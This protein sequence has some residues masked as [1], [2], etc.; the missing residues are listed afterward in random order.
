[1]IFAA[2]DVSKN[3]IGLAIS[4]NQDVFFSTTIFL[5]KPFKSHMD[6]KGIHWKDRL[7]YLLKKYKVEMC[8]VGLPIALNGNQTD[9]TRFVKVFV[10]GIRN[11]LGKFIF[12]DERLSTNIAMLY[13]NEKL[14]EMVARKLLF[15]QVGFFMKSKNSENQND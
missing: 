8:F 3:R 7:Q 15:Y 10:H 12:V 1:M 11:I 5:K 2:L 13:T 9:T 4:F 6:L 14:D